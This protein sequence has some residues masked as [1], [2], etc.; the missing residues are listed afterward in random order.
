MDDSGQTALIVAVPQVEALVGRFRAQHDPASAEGVPAHVTV[1]YP[2]LPPRLITEPVV[3]T[4]RQI[5]GSLP[6]FLTTFS[7]VR[8]F[9]GVLYLAPVPAEPFRQLIHRVVSVFPEAP[10]Y[11]G[12]FSDVV[13]HL[14]VAHARDPVQLETIATELA[15]ASSGSLPIHAHIREVT[16]IE[17][18]RGRWR[19]QMPFPLSR[20]GDAAGL[21]P[22]E[23]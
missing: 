9:P 20:E 11:A 13:P 12:Q 22:Q 14:T 5:F 16:L 2:F 7:E 21:R 6:G 17:K 1:V 8:K 18:Q 15:L 4:L 3:E 10:P 23:P 19:T